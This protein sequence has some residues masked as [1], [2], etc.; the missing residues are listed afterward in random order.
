MRA[1]L[2]SLVRQLRQIESLADIALTTNG[3]LLAEQAASLKAAG[4]DRLNVSLDTLNVETF[5][6]IARRDGLER[7]LEGIATAKAAGFERIRL[8]A[9]ALKGLTE[10]EIVPLARFSMEH[11]L[12]LRFIEFMPLDAEQKWRHDDVLT[13][14][15]IR[16]ILLD[17]GNAILGDPSLKAFHFFVLLNRLTNVSSQ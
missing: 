15:E 2:P 10:T 3:I 7:V 5:R 8:N 12:E 17:D 16:R 13:G 11:D 4:L 1:D 9:I 6:K 14:D